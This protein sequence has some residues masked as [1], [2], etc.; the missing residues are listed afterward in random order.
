MGKIATD[1]DTPAFFSQCRNGAIEKCSPFARRRIFRRRKR[2][3]GR[4]ERT[5][6]LTLRFRY[7]LKTESFKSFENLVLE[8]ELPEAFGY[9]AVSV[10][11]D[12]IDGID[13]IDDRAAVCKRRRGN[14]NPPVTQ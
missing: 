1:S 7:R 3:V 4:G 12:L 6:K 8:T 5:P 14:T 9:D 11:N 10:M 13:G 2:H